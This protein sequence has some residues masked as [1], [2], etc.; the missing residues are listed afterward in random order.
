MVAAKNRS[1]H[2]AK[3]GTSDKEYRKLKQQVREA[4]RKVREQREHEQAGDGDARP[5]AVGASAEVQG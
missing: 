1:G 3:Q 2:G 4:R 5:G